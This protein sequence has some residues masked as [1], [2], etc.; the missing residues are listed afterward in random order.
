MKRNRKAKKYDLSG[1]L[2]EEETVSLTDDK[3]STG[4]F[5]SITA[6]EVM[7]DISS[8]S[9]PEAKTGGEPGNIS[10]VSDASPIGGAVKSAGEVGFDV[11]R[12]MALARE[13]AERRVAGMYGGTGGTSG[14]AGGSVESKSE[15]STSTAEKGKAE[16]STETAGNSEPGSSVNTTG[17][18]GSNSFTGAAG[19][20]EANR[21]G[22]EPEQSRGSERGGE[23]EQGEEAPEGAENPSS[24]GAEERAVPVRKSDTS[25]K[26]KPGSGAAL[27]IPVAREEKP[28]APV[29]ADA[30]EDKSGSGASG[31][32]VV[33]DAAP[34]DTARVEKV[35]RPRAKA[36]SKR[37]GDTPAAGA[38]FTDKD[39]LPVWDGVS[40]IPEMK[41]RLR[42]EVRDR[43]WGTTLLGV[44]TLASLALTG[45]SP[46]ALPLGVTAK[47]L[48]MLIVLL[49]AEII[50]WLS[51]RRSPVSLARDGGLLPMLAVLLSVVP[52]GVAAS[53]G[54]E[55]A[56]RAEPVALFSLTLYSLGRLIDAR[57]V[58]RNFGRVGTTEQKSAA[59]VIK[60]QSVAR[61][62]ARDAVPGGVS[63]VAGRGAV[64]LPDFPRC[65]YDTKLVCAF[66]RVMTVAAAAA[67]V[68][69]GIIGALRG[70]GTFWL[71]SAALGFVAVALPSAGFALSLPVGS[72]S[73]YLKDYGATLPGYSSAAELRETNTVAVN[74]GELF[75]AGT[76]K[77]YDMRTLSR[78]PV[79]RS[80][81]EAAAVAESAGSPLSGIFRE[82]TSSYGEELPTVDTTVYEDR[83]GLSGWVGDRRV[84]IG[85]RTL[86]ENHNVTVPDYSSVDKKILERGFFP[87]YIA[88]GEV[89][90]VL[91]VVGYRA[92]DET[93]AGLTR[94]TDAGYTVVV[95]NC[96]PNLSGEMLEDYFGLPEGSVQMMDTAARK[97]YK[98]ETAYSESARSPAS[99]DGS[100]KGL[101]VLINAS[102]RVGVLGKAM[103]AMC[104]VAA[105]L[106]LAGA[107]AVS[108]LGGT[109]NVSPAV[110][111][112]LQGIVALLMCAVSAAGRM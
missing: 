31:I 110:G 37:S 42:G 98:E 11:D 103:A 111:L 102:R 97:V 75:P 63:I 72:A 64:T 55:P 4:T 61:A 68:V 86:M 13:R 67:A 112:L 38:G 19:S 18:G 87:V 16:I 6:E 49:S 26:E 109:P 46:V 7:G 47:A 77:L 65:S 100:A 106:A 3:Y 10:S 20:G 79:D 27:Y 95:N 21:P 54:N 104:A 1:V 93:A 24:G 90:C 59:V 66:S 73:R 108:F 36:N 51:G 82:I 71:C 15:P 43:A 40:D 91:L 5:R 28:V 70:E 33:P 101:F 17:N 60:R 35:A 32:R 22:E 41:R 44:C 107:A 76:V 62:I 30:V 9:S 92:D 56:L 23:P 94:L 57:R 81:L 89:P 50:V 34:G 48:A 14:A 85:N 96:D 52:L 69:T 25:A 45:V 105:A 2:P 88:S 84:L 29:P 80:L 12:M 58:R 78:H 8:H 39:D 74:C 99:F 83:L 53:A